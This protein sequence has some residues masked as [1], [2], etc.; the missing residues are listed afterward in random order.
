[1]WIVLLL[2]CIAVY[3]WGYCQQQMHHAYREIVE[4][5]ERERVNHET[6]SDHSEAPDVRTSGVCTSDTLRHYEQQGR[7]QAERFQRSLR[8]GQRC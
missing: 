3:C 4:R 8:H 5:S 6:Q 2:L 1:M 7:E